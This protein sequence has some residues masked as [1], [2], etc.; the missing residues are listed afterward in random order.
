M[1][2][3]KDY[4]VFL[5]KLERRVLSNMTTVRRLKQR[6]TLETRVG[7]L[8]R[9]YPSLKH[10]YNSHLLIMAY[11]MTYDSVDDMSKIIHA[12][13][14]ESITRTRRLILEQDREYMAFLHG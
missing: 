4:R 11:W 2:V 9:L 3:N 12:T 5:H 7:Y 6:G 13:P 14:A 1:A 8:F 10:T